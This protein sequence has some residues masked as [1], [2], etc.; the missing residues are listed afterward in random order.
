MH[1]IYFFSN[2]Q[3]NNL[4]IFTLDKFSTSILQNNRCHY[5]KI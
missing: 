3:T 2:T 1:N 5:F 4:Q